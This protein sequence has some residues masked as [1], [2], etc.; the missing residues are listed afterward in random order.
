MP[1]QSDEAIAM[2]AFAT[3]KG[4]HVHLTN[5]AYTACTGAEAWPNNVEL[6]GYFQVKNEE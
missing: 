3:Q 5:D 4:V 6:V 2:M 1:S